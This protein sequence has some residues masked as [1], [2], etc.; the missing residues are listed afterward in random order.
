[1]GLSSLERATP[2]VRLARARPT[3]LAH[4]S[5]GGFWKWVWLSRLESFSFTIF[6]SFGPSLLPSQTNTNQ[7]KNRIFL[8][9]HQTPFHTK[10]SLSFHEQ[11]DQKGNQVLREVSAEFHSLKFSLV[12]QTKGQNFPC[13]MDTQTLQKVV[14]NLNTKP[15]K[16]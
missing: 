11:N 10:Q 8:H 14:H 1:M 15:A 16:I 9:L 5:E 3:S 2:E 4:S 6:H 7:H 12:K 13:F